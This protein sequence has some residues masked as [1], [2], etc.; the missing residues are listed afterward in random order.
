MTRP[1]VGFKVSFA[2][3]YRGLAGR[4]TTAPE[5]I[6]MGVVAG[7]GPAL[8]ATQAEAPPE[9]HLS[10][11]AVYGLRPLVDE[12]LGITYMS[13]FKTIKQHYWFFSQGIYLPPYSRTGLA[14]GGWRI[15]PTG[16]LVYL[17]VNTVKYA[18]YLYSMKMQSQYAA[19][20]GWPT[21]LALSQI[22][23]PIVEQ[24]MVAAIQAWVN[25]TGDVITGR[26]LTWHITG[27]NPWAREGNWSEDT[28][29][30]DAVNSLPK[31]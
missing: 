29:L 14:Q 2:D 24:A 4:F 20:T 23:A 6:K 1:I 31:I 11:E 21:T 25:A 17:I 22:I 5:A 26:A 12:R 13:P 28:P 3:N 15:K 16:K 8:A 19:W 7:Q 10:M 9:K 27:V 30:G 18:K